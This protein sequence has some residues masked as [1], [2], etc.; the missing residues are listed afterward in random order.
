VARKVSNEVVFDFDQ[1]TPDYRARYPGIGHEIREKCPVAWSPNHGGY[2][3]VSGH[4]ELTELARRQDLLSNHHDTDGSQPAYQGISIPARGGNHGGF[5]EMDPPDL[6]DYRKV[7]NPFL[8]PAAVQRWEPLIDDITRA[9]IDDVIE[10][11]E[12]D[13]VDDIAN[14]TPAVLTMAML[15][16]PLADWIIHCE[17]AHAQ[18]YTPPT[19]PD[20][21][22]V[23]EMIHVMRV[24]LAEGV[25]EI[26][27][28]PRPGMIS[29]LIEADF[30]DRKLP[31]E[32][33]IGT[34]G[35][36]IGG[37]FDTTTSLLA[38]SLS[39]LSDHPEERIRILTETGLMDKATEEFVRYFT[40]AQGG[41]RTVTADYE[42]AGVQLEELDRLFLSY[43]LCNHDP[44]VFE[45]P[46]EI[47]ID[48]WPNRHAAFGMGVHRCIG[49]NLARMGFKQMLTQVLERMPEY[50]VVAEG[51]V[52]YE[53]IGVING[54][55]HV[56]ATFKPGTRR[57]TG[58]EEVLPVWQER[59]D[60]GELWE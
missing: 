52:Q 55:Q 44:N 26:R 29:A 30:G 8:S 34:V 51:V 42:I 6:L 39:W 49:S 50:E 46:D 43:A 24:R 59:L 16:L 15:G 22:R 33:I 47:V 53:S 31:D 35:L 19:S 10:T 23:M 14:V 17:P 25:A 27:E 48:R 38:G 9:C 41:G 56:P 13:F 18:V 54:F 7:L 58:L 60:S 12:V 28:N 40:P 5:I 36:L 57:G 3:V 11:G 45:N 32:G 4:E 37:G 20:F 2:W 1:H 21:E